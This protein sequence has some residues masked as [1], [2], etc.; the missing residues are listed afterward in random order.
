MIGEK[1]N[2]LAKLPVCCR[3]HKQLSPIAHRQISSQI[4]IHGTHKRQ[5][6]RY[7]LTSGMCSRRQAK[8]CTGL[9]LPCCTL[10]L[11]THLC[12]Y[13]KASW[14]LLP[15]AVFHCP[16]AQVMC[17]HTC[18]NAGRQFALLAFSRPER[19]GVCQG[20]KKPL[21]QAVAASAA[22]EAFLLT[23]LSTGAFPL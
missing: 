6:P 19:R 4:Q 9:K 13:W 18:C 21:D 3:G 7:A 11:E 14:T 8:N 15:V 16:Y 23:T 12:T 17:L 2:S 10:F 1:K 5:H 22:G 20:T